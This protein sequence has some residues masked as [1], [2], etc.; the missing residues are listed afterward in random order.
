MEH[1][2]G[3]FDVTWL[4]LGL[5]ETRPRSQEKPRLRVIPEALLCMRPCTG[6]SLRPVSLTHVPWEAALV[7]TCFRDAETGLERGMHLLESALTLCPRSVTP[8]SVPLTPVAFLAFCRDPLS[9]TTSTWIGPISLG[10][11]WVLSAKKLLVG[12]PAGSRHLACG[13]EPVTVMVPG[14]TDHVCP[15]HLDHSVGVSG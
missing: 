15:R 5:G 14:C 2:Q 4:P 11:G 10:L 8:K 3:H 13:L 1:S 6:C 9:N 12:Y 7:Q